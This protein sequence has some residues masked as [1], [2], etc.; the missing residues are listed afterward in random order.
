MAPFRKGLFSIL[1][2]KSKPGRA[3]I[4][5]EQ[6]EGA[7]TAGDPERS[8]GGLCLRGPGAKR[9]NQHDKTGDRRG[10]GGGKGLSRLEIKQLRRS[11][12]AGV[13]GLS[14]EPTNAP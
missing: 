14:N 13:R 8:G 4:E 6:C 12:G 9:L 2:E 11:N 10:G 3:L 1:K 7:R 5:R